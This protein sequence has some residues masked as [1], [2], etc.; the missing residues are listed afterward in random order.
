MQNKPLGEF[1]ITAMT[2]EVLKERFPE[3]HKAIY[4]EGFSNGK[5]SGKAEGERLEREKNL[6]YTETM[7]KAQPVPQPLTAAQE[8]AKN[9]K[10]FEMLS[11]DYMRE[12]KVSLGKAMV[13]CAKLYPAEHRAYIEA[14]NS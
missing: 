13:A 1:K 10:Y 4:D 12:H 9:S 2:P 3:V 8:T 5:L 14:A 11:K 6:R 7:T